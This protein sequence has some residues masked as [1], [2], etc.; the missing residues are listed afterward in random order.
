MGD[1]DRAAAFDFNLL[2]TMPPTRQ[3][4]AVEHDGNT[5]PPRDLE[6]SGGNDG[7]PGEVEEETRPQATEHVCQSLTHGNVSQV[8]GI[9]DPQPGNRSQTYVQSRPGNRAISPHG[10]GAV[11]IRIRVHHRP[12]AS[13]D[14]VFE[15]L[16]T[17]AHH[18]ADHEPVPRPAESLRHNKNE[19][20]T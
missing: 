17:Q 18:A 11:H 2:D 9:A 16:E 4:C 20:D 7:V 5:N 19:G 8:N 15:S 14:Y 3:E 10:Q 13:I 1:R 12:E 6:V